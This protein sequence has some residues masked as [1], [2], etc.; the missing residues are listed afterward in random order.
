MTNDPL[1]EVLTRLPTT[2]RAS[3]SPTTPYRTRK[4]ALKFQPE[5]DWTLDRL[6]DVETEYQKRTGRK[7]PVSVRG[8]GRIHDRWGYQHNDSADIGLNPSSPEGQSFLSQLQEQNIPFLAF[9]KAIPG[10]ATGPHIHVGKP[11]HRVDRGL[12]SNQSEQ[13]LSASADDPLSQVLTKLPSAKPAKRKNDPFAGIQAGAGGFESRTRIRVPDV[14]KIMTEATESGRPRTFAEDRAQ[15]AARYQAEQDA[16]QELQRRSPDVVRRL[17]KVSSSSPETIEAQYQRFLLKQHLPNTPHAKTQFLA[18]RESELRAL[19]GGSAQRIVQEQDTETARRERVAKMGT[20]QYL[21]QVPKSAASG[22]V[23]SA[24]TT[25]KGVAALST[26]IGNGMRKLGF[27]ES[28]INAGESDKP[29]ETTDLKTYQLGAYI[30]QSAKDNPLFKSDP[31]LEQ[32]FIVGK[33]PSTIG[34]VASFMLGGWA[35][36]SP[37]LAVVV[38][39]S[40]MTAGDAYD[41]IRAR[42]GTDDEAVNGALLAGGLLGPTELIGMR[43]AMRALSGTARETTLKAA[44]KTALRE[45]RRDAIENALQEFGQEFGQGVITKRPRTE[46]E[47]LE[48]GALG[49]IGGSATVPLTVATGL[50]STQT[51][52][53]SQ[54][55]TTGAEAEQGSRVDSPQ[56]QRFYHRD[57]GEVVKSDDQIGA[58]QSRT[59]VYEAADPEKIHYPKT[60]DLSG[61]GNRRMVPVRTEREGT[62]GEQ[63]GDPLE[64]VLQA[65]Q[66]D[67]LAGVATPEPVSPVAEAK[68]YRSQEPDAG[69]TQFRGLDDGA[70]L[71]LATERQIPKGTSR[72]R[73]QQ[74]DAEMRAARAEIERRRHEPKIEIIPPDT[75]LRAEDSDVPSFQQYVE[76]RPEGGIRFE[77]LEPGSPD[78]NQLAQEY[79]AR[80]GTRPRTTRQ[81]SAQGVSQTELGQIAA[82]EKPETL[83]AQMQMVNR[84]QRAVMLFT[85]GENVL[86]HKKGLTRTETEVGTFIHDAAKVPV[87]EIKARVA[88]GSY[89][90]LLGIVE[91]K[92]AATTRTVTSRGPDGTEIESAIVSPER[93]D[94]QAQLYQDRN[95][96]GGTIE[97]GGA[98]LADQ[99]LRERA[100]GSDS[101][102][103]NAIEDAIDNYLDERDQSI[104]EITTHADARQQYDLTGETAE[105]IRLRLEDEGV[106]VSVREVE[107]VLSRRRAAESGEEG[108]TRSP[109]TIAREIFEG[110]D[111][112]GEL[113]EQDVVDELEANELLPDAV[114]A[115]REAQRD[116]REFGER[117]DI[118]GETFEREVLPK[119]EALMA[120]SESAAQS[121]PLTDILA[122]L[123]TVP[124]DSQGLLLEPAE[125]HAETKRMLAGDLPLNPK[126]IPL[127][128]ALNDAG[129]PT[130]SSGDLYG[131]SLVYVDLP[132]G[133]YTEGQL[134]KGVDTYERALKKAKLPQGWKV[135]RADSPAVEAFEKGKPEKRYSGPR[136]TAVRLIR[137][138]GAVTE[139]E[140]RRVAEAVKEALAT[141]RRIVVSSSKDA[142]PVKRPGQKQRVANIDAEV[143]DAQRLDGVDYEL[144][145]AGDA[146]A[147]RVHDI[148]AGETVAV[149]RYP[150]FADAVKIYS[151]ALAAV[152]GDV[153]GLRDSLPANLVKKAPTKAESPTKK[154]LAQVETL[155][156]G[157]ESKAVTERGSEII[158]R[159][160]I[161][162]LDRLITSHHSDLRANP[163]FP[164]ELQPRERDRAASADQISRIATQLRPEFLGESPKASEGAPIIGPDG[165]V[166]SGNGRVLALRTAYEL[167]NPGS[168]AYKRFLSDSAERLG[169]DPNAISDAKQPVLVRIRLTEVN[170]PQFVKEANEQSIASMSPVEQARSDAKMLRGSLL[171]QFHPSESGDINTA[172]NI[173][174]VRAF[175]RDVVG[176]NERGR[177]QTAAGQ[178]SQEGVT[179]IRNAIFARAYGESPE[180][181]IA[182][183]KMAESPDNNVRNITAAMLRNAAGF[184]SLREGIDQGTRYPLDLAPDVAAAMSKMSALRDQG[185]PVG[186]YLRQ[187]ALYGQELTPVQELLLRTFDENRRG[188][189]TVHA[190]FENYLLGANA[191][192]SPSQAALFGM[193][194]PSKASLLKAAILEESD[195]SKSAAPGLFA[196]ESERRQAQPSSRRNLPETNPQPESAAANVETSPALAPQL[197]ERFPETVPEGEGR[198]LNRFDS[199][200]D[201]LKTQEQEARQRLALRTKQAQSEL[202]NITGE[203]GE[204]GMAVNPASIPQDIYDLVVIGASKLAQRSLNV[205]QFVDEMVREFGESI[206][207]QARDIFK[208]SQ[209]MVVDTQKELREERVSQEIAGRIFADNVPV[210]QQR[211]ALRIAA[212]F[213]TTTDTQKKFIAGFKSRVG[214]M[215]KSY[216]AAGGELTNRVHLGDIM[217][218][219]LMHEGN[220][221]LG[222][223][224]D[225]FNRTKNDFE[226]IR[227]S[228]S[229]IKALE[230][231][232]QADQ[233]LDTPE[234]KEVYTNTKEMLDK[235]RRKL[236]AL[237]YETRDDYFTHI[238][239]VDI[240]DQ[241]ISDA[242]DPKERG[243]NDLVAA[244]SRFLKPR[245]D[246]RSEIKKNLPQVLFA[247]LKSVTKEIAYHDAVSYYYNHFAD[248]IPIS[249]RKHSMDRAIKL[250]QNSLKPEQGRG[251]AFRAAGWARTQQYRNFLAYNLKASVQNLTQVD[252]AKMRW[253]PETRNLVGKL[254]R[255]RKNITGPLAD[256]L[257]V[258]SREQTPL[259]RYLEQFTGD[260]P[261]GSKGKFATAFEK[262]DPF[263]AS[264]DRNWGLTALGSIINSVGK[265]PTYPGL[266]ARLG[267]E[268]AINKLLEKQDVFDAALRE[269]AT[270][271][272]ETQVATNPAMRGEFYDLPLQRI[273]SMFTAFKTRQMQILSEALRSHEG[274]NGARA[275]TIL[276][277]GLSGDAQPVKEVEVLREIE[278]QRVAME[279]MLKKARK[280]REDLGISHG[281]V[282]HMID[283]LKTQERELNGII[284]QIE[285]LSGGRAQSVALVA[286]YMAKVAAV[287]VFFN[288]FWGL[289]YDAIAGSEDDKDAEE[290]LSTALYKAFWDVLPTPFYGADP[291]KLFVGSILPNFERSAS[292]GHITKRG[293][294]KDIVSYGSSVIPFAGIVDRA[295]NRKL[296]GALVDLAVPKKE[297]RRKPLFD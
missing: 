156:V 202:L 297:K 24:G 21:A 184:A 67:D 16:R 39:G 35:T 220:E 169:L 256:A 131:K 85:P 11:S 56:P 271:S 289:L 126:V 238:R 206:R 121:E 63:A 159:Y 290:R 225:V 86:P 171:D 102:N 286:K 154:E 246:A 255:N 118:T 188:V 54:T 144:Y 36:K 197:S 4:G 201:R 133:K 208:Y 203:K 68:I 145:R 51:R 157:R 236:D 92:S 77:T 42:G 160:A 234:K 111:D 129:V 164:P 165:I 266:K 137:K 5:T 168:Q 257:E 281:D 191:A 90:T 104:E 247:Y 192:G 291:T 260:E 161:V 60:S 14:G 115:Y 7:L 219:S 150:K 94:E 196:T 252:F 263:R 296:S 177:Y 38:M 173:N 249:L 134:T 10:V 95:P 205:A 28:F 89:H 25:L 186:D 239:D 158:T 285:P 152:G 268:A 26:M 288:V 253:T 244:E 295:T 151:E 59:K 230:N 17:D 106:N 108:E 172:G 176:D 273:L 251:T 211:A 274:I 174:F 117:M 277:R 282:A 229:V 23:G 221:Y 20:G 93:E 162:D 49:A 232:G 130:V 218:G 9:D 181:L 132:G 287:S 235:F 66:S 50:A 114:A 135:I 88:D 80:Y 116:S 146:G 190:V 105:E 138:G 233:Y 194:A 254:W 6:P 224:Q 41:E 243:L 58:R 136:A 284:K 2:G 240:L 294:A 44:M 19:G 139:T 61:F 270:T 142:A 29:R 185:M 76:D 113:T 55:E 228:E 52:Q 98:E 226:R 43:G 40:G 209:R 91:P 198:P 78:F 199:A 155:T 258:A 149:N 81:Q 79:S 242:K 148:E 101:Q 71:D 32:E 30:E 103:A 180:G 264:E 75:G 250:M 275:Q 18:I 125:T 72:A 15:R 178:L 189:N 193:E 1:S 231:R 248:D 241:I 215:A 276:R 210:D 170:R 261:S 22:L 83:R 147:I 84:G 293:L 47:L 110:Y 283:H 143:V 200:I 3:G 57:W 70:L 214:E 167:N 183:E 272:S 195:A 123:P 8:Q 280:F 45:G 222:K 53:P 278:T 99:L 166:E 213:R 122:S 163:D 12:R 82:P 265:H 292:F 127:V 64:D 140:A 153:R 31:D 27:S 97:R 279:K 237:G 112:T 87:R 65:Q 128:E 48:A 267:A 175:M 37:K 262:H 62:A 96:K 33:A 100:A 227:I 245:A 187:G 259:M 223:I 109:S 216:G 124:T 182:L 69:P 217:R 119:L 141:S 34:Q 179:R 120:Q 73:R 46:Q 13:P 269:S 212:K 204:R 207:K 107:D 74:I